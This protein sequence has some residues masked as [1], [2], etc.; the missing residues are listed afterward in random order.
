MELASF[1]G[2]SNSKRENGLKLPQESF[3]FRIK[4]CLFSER[5]MRH[6][7]GLPREGVES[8]CLGVLKKH[9]GVALSHMV[10]GHGGDGLMVGLDD[11]RVFFQ[12]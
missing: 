1:P 10:S 12:P 2:N 7:N 4:K 9:G 6:W 5:V 3:R 8:L 11:L